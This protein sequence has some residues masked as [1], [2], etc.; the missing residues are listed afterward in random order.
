MVPKS[1]PSNVQ[2][3]HNGRADEHGNRPVQAGYIGHPGRCRSGDEAKTS[4]NECAFHG[5]LEEPVGIVAR[6]YRI[7]SITYAG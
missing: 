2:D 4:V 5:H 3:E 7:Q 6:A 1:L